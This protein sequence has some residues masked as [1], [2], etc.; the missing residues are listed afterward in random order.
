MIQ[1]ITAMKHRY[2]LH[3]GEYKRPLDTMSAAHNEHSISWVAI[4]ARTIYGQPSLE[5]IM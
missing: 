2:E 1:R 5:R 4:S 3:E